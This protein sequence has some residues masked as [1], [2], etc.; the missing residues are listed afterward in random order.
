MDNAPDGNLS[1]IDPADIAEAARWRKDG[2][3]FYQAIIAAGFVDED[4]IALHDWYDYAG[5]LIEKRELT[6]EQRRAGGLSRMSK[7]SEDERKL[8]AN[9]GVAKRWG[10]NKMPAEIP[11]H[12][13]DDTSYRT[14]PTI[15]TIPL[16][17]IIPQGDGF[18]LPD[19]IKKE[20]WAAFIEMRLKIRAP[21]TNSAAKLLLN[22]LARFRAAGDDAGEV[23]N[24]SIMNAWR[25]VWP[26]G[27]G[28][29]NG[30]RT[31]QQGT[32]RTLAKVYT[33]PEDL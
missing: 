11:A 6:R 31:Y 7:L 27:K 2:K 15:P 23:L 4:T 16:P 19:W 8:L 25:G 28:G 3:G 22:R 26:L 12:L 30:A 5:K 21:L 10:T 17:P 14:Q 18:V 24:Q 13:V 32:P 29:G 1:D 20:D 9:K 33:K